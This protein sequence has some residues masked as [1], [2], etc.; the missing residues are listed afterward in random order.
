M[1]PAA[2]FGRVAG[3][4][5]EAADP[6]VRC[7]IYPSLNM[8]HGH[9]K[10]GMDLARSVI[11]TEDIICFVCR[12]GTGELGSLSFFVHAVPQW[13]TAFDVDFTMLRREGSAMNLTVRVETLCAPASGTEPDTEAAT[14]T[15]AVPAG[16]ALI[17][18]RRCV[19]STGQLG[20]D[21]ARRPGFHASD[22]GGVA[23]VQWMQ[24]VLSTTGT[25]DKDLQILSIRLSFPLLIR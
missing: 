16:Q 12:E 8:S 19:F 6:E 17:C 14:G 22:D 10:M 5:A 11:E 2:V 23:D 9:G 7:T 25:V 1:Y 24:L 4:N 13:R 21:G 3:R 15:L 18:S 20:S